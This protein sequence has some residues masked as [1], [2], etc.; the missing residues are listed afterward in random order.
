MQWLNKIVDDVVAKQPKGE[1]LI[2]S[3]S[4]PSGTYHLGHLRELVTCDAI[5]LELQRRGRQA[6]HIQFVDD[7]DAFRKLPIS[8]PADYEQYLG[9]PLC[10]IPAPDGSKQS[11]ADYFLQG[12]KD[13]CTELNIEVEY[14]RAHQK[15][16]SGWYVPA[17][18]K[19]LSKVPEA[20][21]ALETVSGR[22]LED[23]WSPIQVREGERLVK[24]AFE[25]IDMATKNL[26][27]KSTEG[28]SKTVAYDKGGVKLDWRLDWPAHWWL[29]KVAVEPSGRDHMT[30]GGSFDTGVE[31]VRDVYDAEPPYPV[32][33]DFINMVGDTKKMSASKGTGLDAVEGAKLMPPEVVRYFILRPPPSKRLYFDPVNGVVQMMDEYAAFSAKPDKTADEEQLLYI[34]TRGNTTRTVSRIPFSHLVASYQASLKDVDKTLAIIKRTEHAK[35]ATEDA[36]IIRKELKFVGEWLKLRAPEEVKFELTSKIDSNQFN[37]KQKQFLRDLAEKVEQAPAEADGEWFHKTIYDFKETSNL[38]PKELFSTLYTA[39][40]GKTAGPRAG[41]FLSILPRDWLIKRLRLEE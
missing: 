36:D 1:I 38:E 7:F 3:G 14:V 17:I 33:Y 40:I 24:R 30:K 35:L 28:Q 26:A 37:E 27:Y 2:E 39:L 23:T 18:E 11:M 10:D 22:K 19:A 31:I 8:L 4:S 13:A 20:R 25:S 12:L 5:L 34:A 41:W 32:A 16:R 6:R 21:K 9:V 15:Y 29:Q